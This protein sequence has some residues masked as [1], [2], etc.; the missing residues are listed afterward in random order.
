M[1]EPFKFLSVWLSAYDCPGQVA[2]IALCWL[3]VR[4]RQPLFLQWIGRAHRKAMAPDDVSIYQ[5]K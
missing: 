5:K 1:T 3:M 4:G 2:G